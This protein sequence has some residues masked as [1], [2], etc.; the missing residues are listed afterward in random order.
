V[1]CGELGDDTR[2]GG[3]TRFA[4]DAI[5]MASFATGDDEEEA[6]RTTRMDVPQMSVRSPAS[7]CRE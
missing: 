1:W 3:E 5:H 4:G 2:L 6:G 7:V